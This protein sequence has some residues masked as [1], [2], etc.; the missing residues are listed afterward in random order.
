MY[1][2]RP[3]FKQEEAYEVEAALIDC[4]PGLTNIQSGHD[5]ERGVISLEDLC[6][7]NNLDEYK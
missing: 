6:A 7:I 4:Y 2:L 5:S 1:N 3:N